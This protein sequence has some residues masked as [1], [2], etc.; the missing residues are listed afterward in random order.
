VR[1][2]YA[3]ALVVGALGLLGWMGAHAFA[4][5]AERPAFDPE[6]RFGVTGRRVV[7][8]VFGLG[9]AGMSAEFAAKDIPPVWV[10]ALALAGAVAAAWWAGAIEGSDDEGVEQ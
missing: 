2:V 3:L 6:E 4:R 9:M 5:N 10:A 7:A 8:A 1:T